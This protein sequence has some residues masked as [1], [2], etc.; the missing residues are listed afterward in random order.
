MRW[1][2]LVLA[3]WASVA[4][5]ADVGPRRALIGG[6]APPWAWPGISQYQ[7]AEDCY[8]LLSQCYIVGQGVVPWSTQ[9]AITRASAETYTDASGV[10]SY[11]PSGQLA[12]GSAGLQVWESRINLATYSNTG[13][14]WNNVGVGSISHNAGT[15]P[16]LTQTANWIGIPSLR[17]PLIPCILLF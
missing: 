1:L 6:N 5:A 7:G 2:A 4:T 15:A 10:L 12:I 3:L 9:L 13:S 14:F 16:D 8:F 17:T 11:I